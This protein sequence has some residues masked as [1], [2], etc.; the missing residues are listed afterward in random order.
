LRAFKFQAGDVLL[1]QGEADRLHDVV[2]SLGC[3]PFAERGL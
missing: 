3:L 2:S 1:L